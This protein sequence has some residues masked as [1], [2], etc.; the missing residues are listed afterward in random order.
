MY[1]LLSGIFLLDTLYRK[2]NETITEN[3]RETFHKLSGKSY[4]NCMFVVCKEIKVLSVEFSSLKRNQ[5]CH[6]SKSV[7]RFYSYVFVTHYV[8]AEKYKLQLIIWREKFHSLPS[9]N[10]CTCFQNGRLCAINIHLI[11]IH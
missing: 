6:T 10:N 5:F 8:P 1:F 3:C 2:E 9:S 4:V 7:L 11:H